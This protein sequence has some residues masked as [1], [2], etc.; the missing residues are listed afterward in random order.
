MF[1]LI[2]FNQLDQSASL[3]ENINMYWSFLSIHILSVFLGTLGM[4]IL[5]V[6]FLKFTRD[7][8][9]SA[10]EL[11]RL[12]KVNRFIWTGMSLFSLSGLGL[13]FLSPAEELVQAAFYAKLAVTL[14]ILVSSLI[15]T[16]VIRK[17]LTHMAF[18]Y[19]VL[20][21]KN[22]MRNWRQL[23]F[24]NGALSL[25]SWYTALV[26]GWMDLV[27]SL[28]AYLATYLL[29]CLVFAFV[30]LVVDRTIFTRTS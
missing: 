26:Y 7:F 10:K 25:C 30:A 24:V 1:C 15:S 18:N 21:G 12:D 16:F 22:D 6:L 29:I 13:Y 23:T 19:S 8:R 5:S 28:E 14:V 11:A 3:T 17:K 9:I 27:A 2:L 20:S 4:T